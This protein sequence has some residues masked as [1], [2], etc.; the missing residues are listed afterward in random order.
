M[1]RYFDGLKGTRGNGYIM[2]AFRVRKERTTSSDCA[3]VAEGV[4]AAN[5]LTKGLFPLNLLRPALRNYIFRGNARANVMARAPR[6]GIVRVLA[7][8]GNL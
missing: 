4:S 1:Q 8:R 3:C 7:T 2:F 6:S 5:P